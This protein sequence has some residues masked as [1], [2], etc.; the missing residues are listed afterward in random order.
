MFNRT[1]KVQLERCL[2]EL[3]LQQFDLE[4]VKRSVGYVELSPEGHLLYAN[5]IFL[6]WIGYQLAEVKDKHHRTL[7]H[8]KYADSPEYAQFWRRL[9][10]GEKVTDSFDRVAKNGDVVWLEATY[11]P[12]VD[13]QNKV[14]KIIKIAANITKEHQHAARQK[15]LLIALDRS[16]ATIEFHPDGTIKNAN[17][18]FLSLMG[19]QLS[20][21]KGKHHRIF[22]EES[23]YRTNPNFWQ[24]LANGEFKHGQFERRNAN[25][26]CVWIEATYNP[27]FDDDGKVKTIV[28]IGSDITE[29]ISRNEAVQ[30]AAEVACTTAEETDQIARSGINTIEESLDTSRAINNEASNTVTTI[31]QLSDQFKNIESIVETIK[32]I[33]EQT[34]LLALNAAI[35]AARAGEQGRGFA[36]VADEV[37]QLAARTSDSTAEI[38]KVVATNREMM[39]NIIERVQQV[40][41]ISESGLEKMSAVSSIMNEIQK[42]AATVTETVNLLSNN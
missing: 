29:R 21:I 1:I 40:S 4:A 2:N 32:S 27:I 11:L 22:C 12:V 3:E 23:F 18:N 5:P 6:G 8:K 24:Q 14:F 33:A 36:V 28:K 34:N 17:N 13:K 7:C 20:E 16:M 37:R 9:A 26:E 41:A 39:S 31:E 42:G 35:E 30:H 10:N 25:G 15:A 19:Y 38:A